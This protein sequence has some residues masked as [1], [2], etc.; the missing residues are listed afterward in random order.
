MIKNKP[1]KKIL[2]LIPLLIIF[3]CNK[4]G[5]EVGVN[6]SPQEEQTSKANS[7]PP[8]Q[9]S[10]LI[11]KAVV[12]QNGL[13]APTASILESNMGSVSW[14]RSFAGVYQFT[15]PIV[16]STEKV[17]VQMGTIAQVITSADYN[18]D[19]TFTVTTFSGGVNQDGLLN[20]TSIIVEVYP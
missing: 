7:R 17:F 18:S 4:S 9:P 8:Q 6:N 11:Y 1:M 12:T 5:N 14:T 15:I 19:G 13:D 2:L 10:I 20:H 16:P 3:S